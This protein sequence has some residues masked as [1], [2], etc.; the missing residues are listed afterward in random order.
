MPV[1]FDKARQRNHRIRRNDFRS[2]RRREIATNG[3]N[4]PIAHVDV[5]AGNFAEPGI[6]G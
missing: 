4:G 5:A 1:R 2:R 6:H 3:D